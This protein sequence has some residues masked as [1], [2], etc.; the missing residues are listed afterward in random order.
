MVKIKR[1][2]FILFFIAAISFS[3]EKKNDPVVKTIVINE[4]LAI[5]TTIIADQNGE[6][7]D[8]FELYNVTSADIDISGFYLSDNDTKVSKWKVPQG[9]IIVSGGYL[10][11]W[12]DKDTTQAGLHANFKLSAEG[13]EL[14]LSEPDLTLIDKVSY[15]GQTL[16]SSYSRI[17]DGTGDFK[18]QT[19]TFNSS[20]SALK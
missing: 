17:P 12:A 4:L 5:N 13:E 3:C 9:T 6:F 11:I 20:N 16:E 1:L 10:I 18:W 7:D 8:W 15:P 2:F 19:P 14:V